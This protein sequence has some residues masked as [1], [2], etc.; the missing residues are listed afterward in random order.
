MILF[1]CLCLGVLAIINAQPIPTE[2]CSIAFTGDIAE[3]QRV[4]NDARIAVCMIV[5]LHPANTYLLVRR[6]AI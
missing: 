6:R 1:L 5:I 4:V 2:W 3:T